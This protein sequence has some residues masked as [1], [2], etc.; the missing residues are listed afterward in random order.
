MEAMWREGQSYAE[1]AKVLGSSRKIVQELICDRVPREERAWR[2]A[3]K[4]RQQR[5]PEASGTRALVGAA[6]VLGRTPGRTAYDQ[7]RAQGKLDGPSGSAIASRFGSWA[8]ACEMA[9][10]TPNPRRPNSG[11]ATYSEAQ[12]RAALRRVA[13]IL[14]RP[15][16]QGEYRAAKRDGEPSTHAISLKYG[17]WINA[18]RELLRDFAAG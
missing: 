15:P 10:L 2:M 1:I 11:R 13:G 6:R 5:S 18:R 4:L 8:T 16:T 17:G 3:Q 7:L 9:G 14:G 12:Y